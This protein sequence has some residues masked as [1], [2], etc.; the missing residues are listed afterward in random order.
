VHTAALN[1]TTTTGMAHVH[2]ASPS[3]PAANSSKEPPSLEE[4]ESGGTTKAP[5]ES[6]G[7]GAESKACTGSHHWVVNSASCGSV[8][9]A[10]YS[11]RMTLC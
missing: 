5:S 11:R 10:S 1:C 6:L 4:S 3:D 2:V 7:A 9:H 8:S